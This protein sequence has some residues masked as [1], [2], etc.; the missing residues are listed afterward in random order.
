[1]LDFS[2]RAE[3]MK[4]TAGPRSSLV[5]GYWDPDLH[6]VQGWKVKCS[7][8]SDKKGCLLSEPLH[9]GSSFPVLGR[10]SQQEEQVLTKVASAQGKARNVRA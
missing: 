4:E 1:M 5:P 9:G 8:A 10:K 6:V 2:K 7:Q 3:Q